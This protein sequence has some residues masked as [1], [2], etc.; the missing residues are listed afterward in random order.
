VITLTC[1]TMETLR[2]YSHHRGITLRPTTR[3]LTARTLR[4]Y[5]TSHKTPIRSKSHNEHIMVQKNLAVVVSSVTSP[6]LDRKAL[7]WNWGIPLFPS[8]EPGGFLVQICKP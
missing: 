6:S 1:K 3:P 5:S 4:G 8:G 2:A 7:V